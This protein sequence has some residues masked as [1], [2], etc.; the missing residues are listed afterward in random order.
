MLNTDIFADGNDFSWETISE[1]RNIYY[2][3]QLTNEITNKVNKMISML[4]SSLNIHLNIGQE[5]IMNTSDVFMSLETRSIVSLSNKMITQGGNSK[6]QLPSI[7]KTSLSA[8]QTISIR[9][10][11]C[12]VLNSLFDLIPLV[13]D[14]TTS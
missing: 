2:Q 14:E 8:Y 1:G 10:C 6:I 7:L 3:K 9:V 12:R 11:F 13:N 4:T 5:T